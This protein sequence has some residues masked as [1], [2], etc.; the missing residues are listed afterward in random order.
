M[1]PGGGRRDSHVA[2]HAARLHPNRHT[3]WRVAVS[4]IL[5]LPHMR[6]GVYMVVAATFAAG[7]LG[8][9]ELTV[10]ANTKALV[11]D[12]IYPPTWRAGGGGGPVAEAAVRHPDT[13]SLFE[14]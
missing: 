10:Y 4:A 1:V 8:P 11:V 6:P 12:Q 14:F 3:R 9:F 7:Q 5:T 13:K 2:A